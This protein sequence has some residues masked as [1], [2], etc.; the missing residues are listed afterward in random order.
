MPGIPL[1][2]MLTWSNIR[3]AFAVLPVAGLAGKGVPF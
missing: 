1:G 2:G 3:G